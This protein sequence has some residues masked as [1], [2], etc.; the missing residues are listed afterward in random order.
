MD[1]LDRKAAKSH[2]MELQR[3]DAR[4]AKDFVGPAEQAAR[5]G[6]LTEDALKPMF[7]AYTR[8]IQQ[9]RRSPSAQVLIEMLNLLPVQNTYDKQMEGAINSLRK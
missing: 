7:K 5:N 3:A 2:Q 6:R 4:L 9:S 1:L 8:I